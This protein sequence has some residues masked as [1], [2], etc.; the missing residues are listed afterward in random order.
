MQK[1]KQVYDQY[2][3]VFD[4]D[5][6]STSDFNNAILIAEAAGFQVAYSNQSFELWFLL[7]FNLH[8][9]EINRSL[10]ADILSNYLGF[11]Y[12]KEKEVSEKMSVSLYH[13]TE[14]AIRNAKVIYAE[15]P[16]THPSPANEESSTTVFKLVEELLKYV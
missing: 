16:D 7:H 11:A 14:T 6:F 12:T 10:Y 3:V 9:G 5:D 15:F 2:W 1:K 8:Q 4:K 13:L